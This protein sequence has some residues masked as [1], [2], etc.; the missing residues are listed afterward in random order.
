MS[1]GERQPGHQQ[2]GPGERRQLLDTANGYSAGSSEEFVGQA[3]KDF[4]RR[5]EVV[6]STKVWM[7]MRPGPG[8]RGL[9]HA[10]PGGGLTHRQVTKP[11][12]LADAVATV[13]VELD[14]D[15]TAYLEE[16]YNR[17]RPPTWRSPSTSHTPGRAPGS[18]GY[19]RPSTS[20][21][22][23][24]PLWSSERYLRT[25]ARHSPVY[26]LTSCSPADTETTVKP[27]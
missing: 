26:T 9:G 3:V 8:R 11:A 13:D 27:S 12:Q 4:T 25:V 15:D 7:R 14:E 5:E 16:P 24:P 20:P 21:R 1:F 17:T 2:A 23:R 22:P 6:L 10:Q 19:R 18:P